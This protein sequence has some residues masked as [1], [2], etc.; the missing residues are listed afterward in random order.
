MEKDTHANS[1]HKRAGVS[2]D[3][4]SKAQPVSYQ[5]QRIIVYSDKRAASP[6]RPK[7]YRHVRTRYQSSQIL[8]ANI[9][10][11]ETQLCNISSSST[12]HFQ[13]WSQATSTGKC[14]EHSTHRS[15][16]H[17]FLQGT[18]TGSQERTCIR[19]QNES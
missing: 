7:N 2:F 4:D 19:L 13:Y 9:A 12:P 15:R 10:G 5:R 6:G 16:I 3:I 18:E 1:S 17:T 8:E 11:R 14:R